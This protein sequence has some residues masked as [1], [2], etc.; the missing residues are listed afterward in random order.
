MLKKISGT[1][2]TSISKPL[3]ALVRR[4]NA[5][6]LRYRRRDPMR[7]FCEVF[8]E[9]SSEAILASLSTDNIF[10]NAGDAEGDD[11]EDELDV[12]SS[13][14]LSPSL[15]LVALAPTEKKRPTDEKNP[16][17]LS[18]ISEIEK[19]CFVIETKAERD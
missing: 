6:G 9:V 15:L 14:D 11:F 19:S 18:D 10:F 5:V 12:P 1:A 8:T 13:F 17:D 7:W 4:S 3:D 2:S 16:P